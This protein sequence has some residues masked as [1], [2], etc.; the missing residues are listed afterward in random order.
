MDER[1]KKSNFFRISD[2]QVNHPIQ[3]QRYEIDNND[4]EL[5]IQSLNESSHEQ[6]LE[7]LPVKN[8]SRVNNNNWN[9][10][11]AIVDPEEQNL[12]KDI[13]FIC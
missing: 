13:F 1:F 10:T 4:E 6:T 2:K 7:K 11:T 8:I 5:L 3:T 9:L 12:L